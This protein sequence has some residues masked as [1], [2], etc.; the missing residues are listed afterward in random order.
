MSATY[1][2][3]DQAPNPREWLALDGHERVRLA[4]NYHTSA[5]IKLRDTKAHAVYHAIVENQVA[6]GFGPACRAVER[7]QKEGLTRHD[8]IHAVGS[9]I[10][11]EIYESTRGPRTASNQEAQRQLNARLEALTAAQWRGKREG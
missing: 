11:E 5:R 8:A 3:P 9:V 2:D 10:A 7:L 1:Y 4:Q 6:E